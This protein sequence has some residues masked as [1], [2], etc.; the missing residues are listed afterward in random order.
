M[1]CLK[2]IPSIHNVTTRGNS[3]NNFPLVQEESKCSRAPDLYLITEES[4][5]EIE[6]PIFTEQALYIEVLSVS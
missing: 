5:D 1:P 2:N 3:G 6:Y 4:T